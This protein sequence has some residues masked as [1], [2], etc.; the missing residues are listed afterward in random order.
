MI[1]CVTVAA[2][3]PSWTPTTAPLE[4]TQPERS[5]RLRP[6]PIVTR[7]FLISA[8]LV[9]L[10]IALPTETHCIHLPAL[11]LPQLSSIGPRD[12]AADVEAMARTCL[13]PRMQR[14]ERL[15]GL[16][17]LMQRRFLSLNPRLHQIE[18]L[19]RSPEQTRINPNSCTDTPQRAPATERLGGH[20]HTRPARVHP[21]FTMLKRLTAIVPHSG[22]IGAKG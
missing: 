11:P 14:M 5:H 7:Y 1:K 2:I 3:S 16:A 15:A 21:Q 9:F 12:L 4:I 22:S 8:G 13:K 19:P 6:D 20:P 10:P 18:T 17:I